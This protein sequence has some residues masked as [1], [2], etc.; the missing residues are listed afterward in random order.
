MQHKH[1]PR[2]LP[3]FLE[4]VR[5]VGET[6]PELAAKA[7]DGLSKYESANRPPMRPARP[8]DAMHGAASLLD[9]GGSGAP[10]VL[11]PSL[12]NPPQILD[13][14]PKVSLA[15]AVASAGHR[16]LLLDWGVARDR[17]SLDLAQHVE[18]LL[19]PLLESLGEPAALVG[20]CLGGTM[21]V[22]A[23][24]LIETRCVATLAAPWRF[25]GY[26]AEARKAVTRLWENA[27][28]A[29]ERMGALPME[30]L[31]GAF[32][33]LDPER[34]VTKFAAF[35]DVDPGSSN[36]LRFVTLEDWANEGEPLPGPAARELV[37][38][39]FGRTLPELGQW[40]VG[41]RIVTDQIRCPL[42]NVTSSS[43][44]ITPS[45]T[46]PQSGETRSVA[47]GHVGMV[48]GSKRGELHSLL[49][50][51]LAAEGSRR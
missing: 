41:G 47:A 1:A 19:V 49:N 24:N 25:S 21:A 26:P 8:V 34:T 40:R 50:D 7:L 37:E 15:R 18:Q 27:R 16:A 39:L 6:R 23:A 42:L 51:F 44:R 28:P 13:L 36:A 4:L 32:W 46:S 3:L 43:D 45:P 33:S 12:I 17:Q 48:V 10:V 31:Q 30:V 20:Y 9:C 5:I 22:A 35:S 38:D 29:A 11:V 2:P 14:D